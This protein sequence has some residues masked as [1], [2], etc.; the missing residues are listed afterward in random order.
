MN[1]IRII[2]VLFTFVL[3]LLSLSPEMAFAQE[4]KPGETDEF[5]PDGQN[6]EE[7]LALWTRIQK[8]RM[9]QMQSDLRINQDVMNKLAPKLNEI[10]EKKRAIGKERLVVLRHI[11]QLS[12]DAASEPRLK[13]A[14]SR[15]EENNADL[16]R[17]KEH[18]RL[19][20]KE[21]L[22]VKQQADYILFQRK[23]K[24]DLRDLIQQQRKMR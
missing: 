2:F 17:L 1:R 5:S 9:E 19:I 16:E 21:Y 15:I 20:I 11:K 12:K 13:E 24:E 7:W 10:D 3:A 6:Q 22:T 8:I 4:S 23:F 18:T 14:L